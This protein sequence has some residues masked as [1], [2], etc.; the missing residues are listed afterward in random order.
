[1]IK[2]KCIDGCSLMVLCSVAPHR[3]DRHPG[4]HHRHPDEEQPEEGGGA[5]QE[6]QEL[7]QQAPFGRAGF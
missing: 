7:G 6:A 5:A 4:P 1:M 2:D 3:R